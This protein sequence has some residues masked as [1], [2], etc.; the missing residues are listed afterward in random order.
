MKKALSIGIFSITLFAFSKCSAQ[1]NE[2]A[3]N[4]VKQLQTSGSEGVYDLPLPCRADLRPLPLM[5]CLQEQQNIMQAVL[6]YHEL[7]T[8]VARSHAERLNAEQTVS[9]PPIPEPDNSLSRVQWFDENLQVY[10]I[11][12]EPGNLTAYARIKGNEYRLQRNDVIRLAKVLDVHSRGIDLV[13]FGN[14]ISIGLSG[15]AP[16]KE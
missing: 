10:A 12:G 4:T 2:L 11:A 6:N 16:V 9:T 8:K 13:V 5:N 7:R 3:E 14:E 15:L 1:A